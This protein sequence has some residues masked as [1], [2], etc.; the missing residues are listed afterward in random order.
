MECSQPDRC[1]PGSR[2]EVPLDL[3]QM[4][5]L[6]PVSNDGL[7][8]GDD[9]VMSYTERAKQTW[10]VTCVLTILITLVVLVVLSSR[11]PP[12]LWCVDVL[13]LQHRINDGEPVIRKKTALGTAFSISSY[14]VMALLVGMLVQLNAPFN[15]IDLKPL[16]DNHATVTGKLEMSIIV[17]GLRPEFGTDCEDS[18]LPKFETNQ[19][20][21]FKSDTAGEN[22]QTVIGVR[23][24]V[25][26]GWD[27]SGCAVTVVCEKCSVSLLNEVSFRIPASYQ[28]FMAEVRT[29]IPDGITVPGY[30]TTLTDSW[31]IRPEPNRKMLGTV[32]HTS[33]IVK[34]FR[35]DDTITGVLKYSNWFK[36]ASSNT[37]HL[38]EVPD[39]TFLDPTLDS[40]YRFVLRF[41]LSDFATWNVWA[42]PWTTT[43]L[44]LL[45][46]PA[47]A[48][49][50]K[51]V[52]LLFKFLEPAMVTLVL[53][54]FSSKD[55]LE[56][57]EKKEQLEM[58]EPKGNQGVGE[59]LAGLQEA[60]ELNDRRFAD[61][62]MQLDESRAK[63]ESQAQALANLQR[64]GKI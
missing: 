36:T 61:M 58:T 19:N 14:M 38:Q 1:P 25:G 39:D 31:I 2:F 62:Q 21:G 37:D 44:V 20:V 48:T 40:D 6:R 63:V 9:S 46:L 5:V 55:Q 60:M 27:A 52:G 29:F 50:L 12:F 59:Q 28:L 15:T 17:P 43:Q 18:L 33:S 45:V 10:V 13:R 42:E 49:V 7:E 56:E 24:V 53:K 26:A 47:L 16:E 35:R 54:Y 41:E 11:I 22:W 34:V 23:E 51:V 30:G 8:P 32:T 64:Q 57:L 4:L 3:A